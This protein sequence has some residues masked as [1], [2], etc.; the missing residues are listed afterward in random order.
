MYEPGCDPPG[1]SLF[2]WGDGVGVHVMSLGRVRGS[3]DG[4]QHTH[5][6][7]WGRE[8]LLP[9]FERKGIAL[10]KVD[11]YLDQ[12]NTPLSL[13]FEA[14]RFGGH[15][16]RVKGEQG[17]WGATGSSGE[18]V[19]SQLRFPLAMVLSRLITI[20]VSLLGGSAGCWQGG[21]LGE[22]NQGAGRWGFEGGQPGL[23]LAPPGRE[24]TGVSSST[25]LGF[26]DL[27]LS[28]HASPAKPGDEGKVEQGVKDSKSL[29]LPILRQAG[30][31]PPAQE[32]VD[33][34]SRRESLDILVRRGC[35]RARVGEGPEGRSPGPLAA[36]AGGFPTPSV[37]WGWLRA[38]R[39][40]LTHC[41]GMGLGILSVRARGV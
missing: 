37:K 26:E 19:V 32:R 39:V 22:G 40:D 41:R 20:Q 11:I 13:T 29:S 34:Q 8:V 28:P 7:S 30:A 12:S 31:G 35:V 36:P 16:L 18:G 27:Y 21:G 5:L 23:G 17:S 2:F 15:Y 3:Y 4:P 9:V 6:L 33:L 10:G 24:R 1:V 25:G 38:Y 14:Y